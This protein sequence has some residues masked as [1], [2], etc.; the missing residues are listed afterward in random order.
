M[1]DALHLG[2]I[3]FEIYSYPVMMR[4]ILSTEN[5]ITSQELCFNMPSF[6]GKQPELGNYAKKIWKDYISRL[7]HVSTLLER[8]DVVPLLGG[9]VSFFLPP[10]F[11]FGH[12]LSAPAKQGEVAT[13]VFHT[14][15]NDRYARR[16]FYLPTSPRN[17]QNEGILNDEGFSVLYDFWA[18][19]FMAYI[20]P[21]P[22]PP[23]NWLIPYVGVVPATEINPHGVAF[24][25]PQWIR[26]C[27]H[28]GRA[29][30]GIAL[31]WP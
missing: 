31:S 5:G 29:P 16:R 8:V 27:G 26:I 18:Q 21:E 19:W 2:M 23:I 15:H 6:R 20:P 4:Y 22:V 24:R 12:G 25:Q 9:E 7:M 11:D 14:G 1:L 10:G 13:V 28:T 3:P 30:E 17:W